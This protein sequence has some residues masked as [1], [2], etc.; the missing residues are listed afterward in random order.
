MEPG[1][2]LM[3]MSIFVSARDR[4]LEEFVEKD[5]K[6]FFSSYPTQI[7]GL[8]EENGLLVSHSKYVNPSKYKFVTRARLVK[9]GE[10]YVVIFG[11]NNICKDGNSVV[12][13][14]EER[15]WDIDRK[16]FGYTISTDN[17][18]ITKGPEESIQ[19]KIC[20]NTDDQIFSFK[21]ADLGGCGDIGS[22]LRNEG[23]KNMTTNVNIFHPESECPSSIRIK[24]KGDVNKN[25][26]LPIKREKNRNTSFSQQGDVSSYSGDEAD[27]PLYEETLPKEEEVTVTHVLTRNP[28]SGVKRVHLDHHHSPHHYRSKNLVRRD[29]IIF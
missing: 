11:E 13:C 10:K 15:P 20:V 16:E 12:K 25:I 27:F 14:K 26:I 8:E 22:L 23:R 18:C 17:K 19:M 6:V 24:T 29:P 7:L 21:L 3:F 4:E 9:S 2:I 28:H 5:I 1:L